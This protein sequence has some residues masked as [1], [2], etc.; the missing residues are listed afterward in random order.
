MLHAI[1][2][3]YEHGVRRGAD[4]VNRALE[5]SNATNNRIVDDTRARHPMHI[6]QAHFLAF[7]ENVLSILKFRSLK[8]LRYSVTIGRAAAIDTNARLHKAEIAAASASAA[9]TE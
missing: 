2:R 4:L 3:D 6:H 5:P 1:A 7:L 9:A 8:Q